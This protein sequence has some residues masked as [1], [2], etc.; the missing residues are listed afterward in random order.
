MK[1]IIL[2]LSLFLGSHHIV[3]ADT[4]DY[5]HI[6]FNDDRIKMC[7]ETHPAELLFNAEKIQITDSITVKPSMDRPCYDCKTLL[8][9]ENT[10]GSLLATA[11]GKGTFNP[12]T[13]SLND[14]AHSSNKGK[15]YRVFFSQESPNSKEKPLKKVFLFTI[16][17]H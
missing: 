3:K 7:D 1:K 9:V 2:I 4:T 5:W 6:Y 10:E 11:I 14:V 12:I 15:E 13:F 8:F 17:I 16:R